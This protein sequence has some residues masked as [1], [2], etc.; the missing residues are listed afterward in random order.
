METPTN[1]PSVQTPATTEDD[2]A[3][4]TQVEDFAATQAEAVAAFEL[5]PVPPCQV[6]MIALVSGAC[7]GR[8]KSVVWGHFEKVKIGEGDTSKT[9]AIC[10]YCQKFYNAD[11]KSC[12]TSNLLAHVPICPKNPNREYLVKWQKTLAFVPKKDGEDG[13]HPMSTSFSVEASK[14]HWPK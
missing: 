7:S 8:K 9:K 3:I 11:S 12:G 13:F 4:P 6:S 2:G 10:N 5:P 1:E 14:R